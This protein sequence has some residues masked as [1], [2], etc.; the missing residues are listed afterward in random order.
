MHP[1]ITSREAILE[2]SRRLIREQG[3]QAVSIRS[4]ATACGVSVGSIYNYFDNKSELIAATVE[5]VWCEIFHFPSQPSGDMPDF[6][7]CI[8]QLY[9]HMARGAQTYPGFFALHA[10]SFCTK[11]TDKGRQLMH[12]AWKHIQDNLHAVLLQDTAVRPDAFDAQFTRERF[13]Q[14]IFSLILAAV[15]QQNYDCT[16]VLEVINRTLYRP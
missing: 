5:S 15:L 7:H 12:K 14:L 6:A 1:V 3:W 8:A 10:M 4:V 13:I 9:D 11:D 16:A 2:S